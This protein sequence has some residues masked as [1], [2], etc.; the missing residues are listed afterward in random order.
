MAHAVL[1]PNHQPI[2]SPSKPERGQFVYQ[3]REPELTALD[4]GI[5]AA[6]TLRLP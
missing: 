6:R 1:A 4:K 2:A 5:G 3:R